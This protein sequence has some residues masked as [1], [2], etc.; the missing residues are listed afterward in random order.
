MPGIEYSIRLCQQICD[1]PAIPKAWAFEFEE[2]LTRTRQL[3]QLTDDG[4]L[5]HQ[6]DKYGVGHDSPPVI[7]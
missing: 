3:L 4:I 7:C 5:S 1:L 2:L 6:M